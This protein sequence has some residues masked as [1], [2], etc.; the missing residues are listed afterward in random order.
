MALNSS[1]F[2]QESFEI[3]DLESATVDLLN[4]NRKNFG[5]QELMRD[6][7][8]DAVAF[9]QAS[10]ILK[11]KKLIHTQEDKKM[12]TLQD[13][14]IVFEGF[15]GLSAENIAQIGIGVKAVLEKGGSKTSVTTPAQMIKAVL[16]DWMSDEVS[17]LNLIQKELS[18]VGVSVVSEDQ[19]TFTFVVVTSGEAYVPPD[20]VKFNSKQYGILPFESE[21]CDPFIKDHGTTESLFSDVLSIEGNQIVFSFHSASFVDHIINSGGDAFVVDLIQRDQYDCNEANNV[22]PGALQDGYLMPPVKKN[23]LAALNTEFESGKVKANFG[24]L[25]P[26]LSKENVELNLKILKDNHYCLT[27]P[28]NQ[29]E[30]KNTKWYDFPLLQSQYDSSLLFDAID[31]AH[32]NCV[33]GELSQVYDNIEAYHQSFQSDVIEVRVKIEVAP[34]IDINED[35]IRNK[36]ISILSI[37]E[38]DSGAVRFDIKENWEAYEQFKSGTYYQIETKGMNTDQEIAYLKEE[39]QKDEE[40]KKALNKLTQFDIAVETYLKPVQNVTLEAKEKA[41]LYCIDAEKIDQALYLQE[42]IYSELGGDVKSMDLLDEKNQTKVTLPLINN[43]I[44][45][46]KAIDQKRFDGNPIHLAFLELYFVQQ[47]EP[48]IAYNYHLS[49]L[50]HWAKSNK[51]VKDIEGWLKGFAKI[52]K[53]ELE[54][55][56]VAKAYLN[57][58]II[59]GDYY[60]EKQ[61]FD[62]RKKAFNEV[63][64]WANKAGLNDQEQ[65]KVAKYLCHQDQFSIAL[66]LL[67]P[68]VMKE[69]ASL[70]LMTYFLQAAIYHQDLVPMATY[71]VVLEK[72]KEVDKAKFC[73]LFSIEKMGIQ[74]TKHLKIKSLYCDNCSN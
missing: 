45:Q 18:R 8:L 4:D 30:T 15:Y 74:M 24:E 5:A 22:F 2:A 40:L 9:E 55:S 48:T 64:K 41:M 37:S 54:P 63:L 57:Y 62:K 28:F 27:V 43:Q 16:Y 35:E 7:I 69:K 36:L 53:K 66:Q 17:Q 61:N 65:L 51:N 72:L 52:N 6:E 26:G 20:G 58:W 44:L 47:S 3:E 21:I 42:Q 23:K 70:I 60:Y 71:M 73:Q 13:R 32:H 25:P 12:A 31:T 68:E 19:K 59:A 34:S 29:I 1:A 50:S 14:L 11:T 56:S 38:L 39:Y 49:L 46:Q 33:L 67:K 10:Y